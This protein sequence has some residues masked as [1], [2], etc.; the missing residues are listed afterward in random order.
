MNFKEQMQSDI[1]IFFNKEEF[2]EIATFNGVEISVIL[3]EIEADGGSFSQTIISA[4]TEDIT[5]I[6]KQSTFTVGSV[7]YGVVSWDDR[8]GITQILAQK[9]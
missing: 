6:T 9:R 7:M 2:A 1:T 3:D 8:A 4:K 5:T